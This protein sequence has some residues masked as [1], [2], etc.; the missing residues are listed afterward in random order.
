M[1]SASSFEA[2]D[3]SG[4]PRAADGQSGPQAGRG[5]TRDASRPRLDLGKLRQARLKD[6]AIRFVFGGTISV[7]AALIGQWTTIRFGGIFTAF[8]AILLASLTLIGDQDGREASAEDAEGGVAGALAL[9][10]AAALLAATLPHMS[11]AASLLA[12]LLLWLLLA[13]GLY[14]LAV[15]LGWLRTTV[16]ES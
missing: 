5:H 16:D 8:P 15:R 12:S 4:A 7:L 13:V 6:Y 10:I 1:N 9:A 3:P 11:G 2:Q 14:G